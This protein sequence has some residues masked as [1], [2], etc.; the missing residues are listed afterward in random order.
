MVPS[1]RAGML[2]TRWNLVFNTMFTAM[3]RTTAAQIYRS[4]LGLD[5]AK[6]EGLYGRQRRARRLRR[7][8]AWAP[9]DARAATRRSI[10]SRI[11]SPATPGFNGGTPFSYV[12]NRMNNMRGEPER[13]TAAGAG[14]GRTSSDSR[15]PT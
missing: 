3:P 13:S 12:P 7:R 11:R 5:I 1:K 8:R 15:S 6:S 9:T 10:R 2:T 14:G 4:Y